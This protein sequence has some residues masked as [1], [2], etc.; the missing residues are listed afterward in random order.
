MR[1]MVYRGPGDVRLEEMP[2]PIA[3][4][5]EL[6]IDVATVG[7]CGTDVAEYMDEPRFFPIAER[8]P[9]SGHLGPTIPGHEFS[10]VVAA[11]GPEVEDFAIG[12]LVASGAG[13]SCG[14]CGPCR[15]GATNMCVAYWTVGLHANGAMAEMVAVPASCCLNVSDYGIAPDVAALAQPMSIAVHACRRGRL[16]GDD[17]VLV[18]GSGG[19]GS[20]LTFCASAQGAAVTAVDLDPGR[21]E[22]AKAL[23]A[24]RTIDASQLGDLEDLLMDDE[25][26][27]TLVFECT[28]APDPL[29]LAVRTVA[30]NGRV[31]VVGHQ[32]RRLEF[33]FKLLT[34][35]EKEM[36]G[37][38]AH[39]FATDFSQAVELVNR[40]PE[41]WEHLAPTVHPLEDLVTAGL[42]PMA[43]HRQGQVKTLFDPSL[44]EARPLRPRP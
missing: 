1:A 18:M 42:L 9:H 11:V 35:G 25:R 36:I 24:S 12:D 37:T 14:A 32:P 34:F 22:M 3:G 31:V 30:D 38:M 20:F 8:H 21:L 7:I 10:G 26:R 13:V 16:S 41:V 43:E 29:E 39:V 19:I 23:G 17:V 2:D 6:L 4:P 28:A 15:R 5:G 44:R 33:D 40:R 27:P